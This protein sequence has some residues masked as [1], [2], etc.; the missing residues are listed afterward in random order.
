[1]RPARFQVRNTAARAL[2]KGEAL[3]SMNRSLW[4][5]PRGSQVRSVAGLFHR[6]GWSVAIAS[7]CACANPFDAEPQPDLAKP[8]SA[9]RV[10]FGV[11]DASA[12]A[13]ASAKSRSGR[14]AGGHSTG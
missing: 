12:S 14:F 2:G 9:L 7:L 13:S 8:A 11:R 3:L 5:S 10:A 1:L 6:L 4:D